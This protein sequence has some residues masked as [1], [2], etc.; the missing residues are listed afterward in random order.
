MHQKIA[1]S[2]NGKAVQRFS[3]VENGQPMR[4]D[5]VAASHLPADR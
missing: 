2:A 1:Y 3:T 4:G 5:D